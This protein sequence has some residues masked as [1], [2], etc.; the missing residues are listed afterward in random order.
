M[1]I[2]S[3]G[4]KT[5]LFYAISCLFIYSVVR[6]LRPVKWKMRH[7]VDFRE[8]GRVELDADERKD[9]REFVKD[10]VEKKKNAPMI[11]ELK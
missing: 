4:L 7:I 8:S 6:L 2:L 11:K 5:L 9:A 3:F 1:E 10:Q